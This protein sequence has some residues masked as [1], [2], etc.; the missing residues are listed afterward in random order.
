MMDITDMK[1]LITYARHQSKIHLSDN[2]EKKMWITGPVVTKS[3][4]LRISDAGNPQATY[5]TV[6]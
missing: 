5:M 2:T 4:C 3:I 1:K 6:G